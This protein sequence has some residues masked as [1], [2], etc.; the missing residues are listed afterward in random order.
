MSAR[1]RAESARKRIKERQGPNEHSKGSRQMFQMSAALSTQMWRDELDAKWIGGPTVLAFLFSLPHSDA[2][3]HLDRHGD[4]LDIRSG[5]TWDLFWP[6]YYRSNATSQFENNCGSESVGRGFAADWY[7]NAR[8][9]NKMR[10]DIESLTDER[11]RF[12]GGTDLVLVNAWIPD[13][14]PSTIDWTSTLSGPVDAN[15]TLG[16]GQ[17]VERI[18]R[19]LEDD[20]GD[21]AYGVAEVMQADLPKS[22]GQGL[23]RKIAVS[24]AAEIA[25]AI[26]IKAAGL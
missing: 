9:F 20:D 11:W 18:S 3:E 2:I 24:V 8:E 5:S 15:T 22:S 1:Q 13:R 16:L 7:F 14:G 12:S 19:D 25:A 4:Y 17:I 6:G 21:A 26:G 23:T 10:G